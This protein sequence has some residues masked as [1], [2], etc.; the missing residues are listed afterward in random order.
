MDHERMMEWA[1]KEHERWL[2]SFGDETEEAQKKIEELQR[3]ISNLE[4]TE[5]AADALLAESEK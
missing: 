4:T 5:Q 2:N 3:H 1:N